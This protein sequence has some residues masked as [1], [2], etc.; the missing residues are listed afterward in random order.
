VIERLGVRPERVHVIPEAVDAAFAPPPRD[1]AARASRQRFGIP[2]RYVLY[3][4]QFDPRKNIDGLLAAF[5]AAA[6]DDDGLR[7]VI[8]GELGKLAVHLRE[9]L[10]RTSAP[11]ERVVVTGW[12][13]D[14]TLAALYAGAE[15]LVHAALLEGFGLTPLESLAAGTPVVGYRAGAVEE[16]V[17]DA[18]LLVD[19]AD[20]HAL[21]D[22]LRRFLGSEDLARDLRSRAPGRARLF[23]WDAAAEATL[24]LYR[25]L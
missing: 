8:A 10:E 1:E 23:S 25:A 9:A 20:A 4:G 2:A 18:G 24:A 14:P 7:L 19:P 13:D 6:R 5:A 3:V 17:G 15:C 12:V 16:V 11:R 21:G 22:A